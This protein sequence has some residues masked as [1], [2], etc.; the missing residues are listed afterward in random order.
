MKQKVDVAMIQEAKQIRFDFE[1]LKK[2][3]G[4]KADSHPGVKNIEKR[5]GKVEAR[6]ASR[7]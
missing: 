2:R 1:A 4:K 5:L 6:L 7:R 3:L